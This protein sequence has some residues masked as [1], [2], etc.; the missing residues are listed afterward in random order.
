MIS[1]TGNILIKVRLK[2]EKKWVKVEFHNLTK[3]VTKPTTSR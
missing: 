2:I 3:T 1:L